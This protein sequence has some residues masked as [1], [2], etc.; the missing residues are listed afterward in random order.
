MSYNYFQKYL[1]LEENVLKFA[2]YFTFNDSQL[3]VTSNAIGD[4]I[5][6]IS[7]EIESISKQMYK[8]ETND[9]SRKRFDYDCI[10]YF[11]T[12]WHLDK[13][14]VELNHPLIFFSK[15]NYLPFEKKEIKSGG[16]NLIFSWNNAYQ[17]IKHD[18][19]NSLSF[20]T[21]KYLIDSI[22][23]LYLLNVYY[24][25]K[26]LEKLDYNE[27]ES[28]DTKFN[29]QLFNVTLYKFGVN[30]K[31]RI[32]KNDVYYQSTLIIVPEMENYKKLID[33]NNSNMNR[34]GTLMLNK[35]VENLGYKN[36]DVRFEN[37]QLKFYEIPQNIDIKKAISEIFDGMNKLKEN[38][39]EYEIKAFEEN[40]IATGQAFLNIK[41][42]I[43]INKN[44]Y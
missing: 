14:I 24:T 38:S 1:E 23:A 15:K 9:M 5:L 22:S 25:S 12:N 8:N 7:S 28:I 21:V 2:N 11:I 10:E 33:I 44:Q 31:E 36:L 32:P 26:I 34:K 42:D 6:L 27:I 17:N 4:L 16:K 35:V 37:N 43:E 39:L 30:L 3:N 29:S 20:Q 41:Y 13:K 19:I 40:K 18:K